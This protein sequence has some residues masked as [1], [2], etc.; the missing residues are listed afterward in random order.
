MV[1]PHPGRVPVEQRLLRVYREGTEL[2]KRWQPEVVAVEQLFNRNVTNA[3][4]VDRPGE[5][6][7][8]WLPRTVARWRSTLPSR[9]N[10]RWSATAGRQN[11]RWGQWFGSSST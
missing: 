4:L 9:L 5:S 7:Y 2:F 8:S 6:A 1:D 10:R 11:S 3:F